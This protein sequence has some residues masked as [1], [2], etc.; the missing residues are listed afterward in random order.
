[1][2]IKFYYKLHFQKKKVK[3]EVIEKNSKKECEKLMKLMK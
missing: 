2:K 1:M 3:K